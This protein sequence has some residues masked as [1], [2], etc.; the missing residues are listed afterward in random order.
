MEIDVTEDVELAA[1]MSTVL[2]LQAGGPQKTLVI[3]GHGLQLAALLSIELSLQPCV[4]SRC[5]ASWPI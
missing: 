4:Q 2:P 1:M 3:K 5:Q